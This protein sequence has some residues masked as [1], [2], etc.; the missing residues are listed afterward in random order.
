MAKTVLGVIG[1]SG[2]Y[3]MQGLERVEQVELDTPFGRPSDPYFRGWL[4]DAEVVFL[5]RHG[6]GHRMMPSELN[7]RAN[8][9]GMKQLGVDHLIS[10]S[11][12]GSLREELQPGDLV[13]PD[14]FIDRTFKR[15]ES[16]FGEGIVVH[17][18][19]ADPVCAALSRELAAAAGQT[20]SRVHRG[21]TYLCIEGPQ[22]STRAESNLYR[23]WGA[24]VISM[25]AMQEARLAREAEMCYAAL[26]LVTDY[27]CW[28]HSV[29]AVDIAEILRVMRLN[30]E[31]AQ[32]AIANLARRVAPRTRDCACPTA[33]R[34]T[35]VTDKAVI[36][37][38]VAAALRPLIGKYL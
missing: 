16:F 2:F 36:P 8:V 3:Q 13:V 20:A 9:F 22:F 4:G 6:R 37:P 26:V 19:L 10:V 23:Q 34:D 28:H 5:S 21:G 17:V 27:D 35:I 18:S 38:K 1:G 30:V 15:P 11:T 29:A 25:T 33:L 31:R 14:Q 32:Q 24:D 12:A 7:F